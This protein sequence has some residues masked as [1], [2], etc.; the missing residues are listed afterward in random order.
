MMK[1]E[2]RGIR[3]SIDWAIAILLV[4]MLVGFAVSLG[5]IYMVDEYGI[6]PAAL[7]GAPQ[8]GPD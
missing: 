7:T 2:S 5:V 1:I 8:T 6:P 3:R 4:L